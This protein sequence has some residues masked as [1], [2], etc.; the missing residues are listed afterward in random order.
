MVKPCSPLKKKAQ[1]PLFPP[2]ESPSDVLAI[3]SSP[4]LL[5]LFNSYYVCFCF[6]FI[7]GKFLFPSLPSDGLAPPPQF[8]C[9]LSLACH[10]F[11][12]VICFCVRALWFF[13]PPLFQSSNGSFFFLL[14]WV[15]TPL[16]S[17]PPTPWEKANH[18]PLLPLKTA[19]AH[20]PPALFFL[21][22]LT[23]SGRVFFNRQRQTF[24]PSFSSDWARR[25][26]SRSPR[27][28]F[29]PFLFLNPC[30]QQQIPSFFP[31]PVQAETPLRSLPLLETALLQIIPFQNSFFRS[32]CPFSL[33]LHH[34]LGRIFIFLS[35]PIVKCGES[36]FFLS[37]ERGNF[38]QN[39]SS[40]LL[41]FWWPRF[42]LI[43]M[44]VFSLRFS[45][46]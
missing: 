11:P 24:F 34:S 22:S 20:S 44:T 39:H 12:V 45:C 33:L 3:Q 10:A 31:L 14:R 42:I 28:L 1:L 16:F 2:P 15:R 36:F 32:L 41:F 30:I 9:S 38:R 13:P 25:T 7:W 26:S 8:L 46:E 23:K 29:F 27:F 43:W 21:P 35:F 37:Q 18:P 4:P 17:F 5:F 6:S 40:P 19:D